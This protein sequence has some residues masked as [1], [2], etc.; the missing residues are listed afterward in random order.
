MHTTLLST[1][2]PLLVIVYKY[3]FIKHRIVYDSC[4]VILKSEVKRRIPVDSDLQEGA[5]KDK[6]REHRV[7]GESQMDP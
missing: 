2:Q 4:Y 6:S 5:V 3:V 7:D 1:S